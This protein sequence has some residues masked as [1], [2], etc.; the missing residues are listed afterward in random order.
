MIYKKKLQEISSKLGPILNLGDMKPTPPATNTPKPNEAN[1]SN[2]NEPASNSSQKYLN[3]TKPTDDTGETYNRESTV[4]SVSGM[5][6]DRSNSAAS[7]LG[8][9]SRQQTEIMKSHFE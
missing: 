2:S 8:N 4:A 3:I 1:D 5:H 7:S 6:L 9:Y